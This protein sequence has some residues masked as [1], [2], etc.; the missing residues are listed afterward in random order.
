VK[1]LLI[2]QPDDAGAMTVLPLGAACIAAALEQAGHEVRQLSLAGDP[3]EDLVACL[4]GFAAEVIGVSVRNIDDQTRAKPVFFLDSL[5]EAIACCRR[6]STAPI[7]LGGAGF[8]IFPQSVLAYLEADF[9]LRG[10][11]EGAFLR[12]L[13]CLEQ[14]KAPDGVPSLFRPDMPPLPPGDCLRLGDWPLPR[15]GR[16]L[17]LPGLPDQ[18]LWVPV[19]SR[20]GCPMGCSYCSTPAIEGERR[21][22][23]PVGQVVDHLAEFSAAGC[24]HFFL[25]DNTF[26]LPRDYAEALCDRIIEAGLNITWRAILYPWQVSGRLIAKMAKAGCVEVSLGSESGSETMLGNYRKRFPPEEVRRISLLLREHGIRQL[27]FWL[28]GGPGEDRCTVQE[29]LE[30]FDSLPLDALKVTVGLRIY[31]ETPL[32]LQALAEGVVASGDDLLR[33]RFYLADGLAGWLPDA[34]RAWAAERPHWLLPPMEGDAPPG[35]AA[36]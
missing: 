30:F 21:R 28:V 36:S 20:R 35:A 32:A 12:L 5:R 29:S 22:C 4:T 2:H 24:D 6:L 10:E 7:V 33:P 25:V 17:A 31:P 23:R 18:E 1:V 26:N 15:P 19:Q 3:A 14:G 9:G 16:H 11:G 27:G 34:L 13:D 8:S